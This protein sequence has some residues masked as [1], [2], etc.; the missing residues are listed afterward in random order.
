MYVSER[1]KM[2]PVLFLLMNVNRENKVE[3][4]SVVTRRQNED[5][6]VVPNQHLDRYVTKRR[7]DWNS[8]AAQGAVVSAD[9]MY[10]FQDLVQTQLALENKNIMPPEFISDTTSIVINPPDDPDSDDP[11]IPGPSHGLKRRRL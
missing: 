9:E 3:Q 2:L 7:I 8:N 5:F 11:D 6:V 1:N 10:D 4:R